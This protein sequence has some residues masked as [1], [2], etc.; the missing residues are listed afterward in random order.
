[1]IKIS[2]STQRCGEVLKSSESVCRK[3]D[4]FQ[5]TF[6]VGRVYFWTV[7]IKNLPQDVACRIIPK[8]AAHSLVDA[9]FRL[10]GQCFGCNF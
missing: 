3:A 4:T 6:T 5:V 2:N 1:M 8:R 9:S 10:R 7:S